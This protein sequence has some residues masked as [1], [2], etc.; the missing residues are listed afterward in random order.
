MPTILYNNWSIVI[1]PHSHHQSCWAN[2][3]LEGEMAFLPSF[4]QGRGSRRRRRRLSRGNY[5]FILLQIFRSLFCFCFETGSSC[6]PGWP[7]SHYGAEKGLELW[8]LLPPQVFVIC[9][10]IV[11]ILGTVQMQ[12]F[13]S[14]I[15]FTPWKN[16]R[17]IVKYPERG[18]IYDIKLKFSLSSEPELCIRHSQLQLLWV[19]HQNVFMIPFSSVDWYLKHCELSPASLSNIFSPVVAALGEPPCSIT[20]Q[21]F[22]E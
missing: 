21:G 10:T 4:H 2:T 9:G 6:S 12:W 19:L 5:Y 18:T 22:I 3:Q 15:F 14:F 1:W 8:I 13:Y 16:Q 17:M 20:Q 7:P 11:H